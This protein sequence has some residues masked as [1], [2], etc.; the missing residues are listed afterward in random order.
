MFPWL[1]TSCGLG[2]NPVSWSLCPPSLLCPPSV[3]PL[4]GTHQA[5][6]PPG[7]L[8]ARHAA[9]GRRSARPTMPI[10]APHTELWHTQLILPRPRTQN[11]TDREG[12]GR[13]AGGGHRAPVKP[14]ADRRAARRGPARQPFTLKARCAPPALETIPPLCSHDA[15]H[16]KG[17]DSLYSRRSAS[18]SSPRSWVALN[19]LQQSA[20]DLTGRYHS[21]RIR[22]CVSW[23]WTD[24]SFTISCPSHSSSAAPD[25]LGFLQK[26]L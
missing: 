5:A 6:V 24:H 22:S 15:H 19:Y 4:S 18:H 7:R 13:G 3:L 16:Y 17:L 14:R 1:S 11:T 21:W 9:A 20:V 26:R 10:Q 2:Q 25:V 8:G 23:S 12:W